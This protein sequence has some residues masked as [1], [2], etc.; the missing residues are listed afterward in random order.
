MK[1]PDVGMWGIADGQRVLRSSWDD[2][3]N[4]E[5]FL[6][7]MLGRGKAR[8]C[9]LPVRLA[10]KLTF[11]FSMISP[12]AITTGLMRS[13]K[14]GSTDWLLARLS[15]ED[16]VPGIGRGLLV[17]LPLRRRMCPSRPY[18]SWP[19]PAAGPFRGGLS[20]FSDTLVGGASEIDLFLRLNRGN[21]DLN[22]EDT[23]GLGVRGGLRG[24]G[25]AA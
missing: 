22:A 17:M 25:L 6:E 4:P 3:D 20:F 23:L 18:P 8:F 24:S 5:L 7:P 10:S 15:C 16:M 21:R 9:S 12:P 11:L 2:R 13:A 14:N 1:G 19:V